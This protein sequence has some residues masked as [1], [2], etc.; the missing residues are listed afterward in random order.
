MRWG[1][2]SA[3]K[4]YYILYHTFPGIRRSSLYFRYKLFFPLSFTPI[5]SLQENMPVPNALLFKN[6]Q[7][8]YLLFQTNYL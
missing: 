2:G 1:R 5:S 4:R 3:H 6:S 8:Y 7:P